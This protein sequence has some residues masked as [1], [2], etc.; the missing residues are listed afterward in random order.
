[1][2]IVVDELEQQVMDSLPDDNTAADH[3]RELAHRLTLQAQDLDPI[4]P[5]PADVHLF[6][7]GSPTDGFTFRAYEDHED[8]QSK[9]D[10]SDDSWWI[11]TV[12]LIPRGA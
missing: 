2:S 6:I 8:A 9:G 7:I 11:T 12:R 3:L 10:R 5:E 4:E 1:M